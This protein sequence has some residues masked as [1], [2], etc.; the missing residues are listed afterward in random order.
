LKPVRQKENW[1]PSMRKQQ[2]PPSLAAFAC[3]VS[4]EPGTDYLQTLLRETLDSV[5]PSRKTAQHLST[6]L[7]VQEIRS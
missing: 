4:D 6:L 3:F 2:R 5:L 7:H 1:Q